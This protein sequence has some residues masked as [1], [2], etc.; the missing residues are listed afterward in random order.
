MP[1][2]SGPFDGS[3]WAESQ[4]MRHMP[5]AMPSGVI[6]TPQG[7][8][9][10]GPL[11]F[12]SSGLTITP[13]A[14]DAN[15]GGAG[16]SRTAALGSVT[17]A[18][19]ANSTL[20]RRDR[21]VLRR[22]IATHNVVLTV[23]QGTA[24]ATPVAPSITRDATTFDLPLF[25]FLVPPASGTNITGVVD[26]R[27][28]LDVNSL[29]HSANATGRIN[30]NTGSV[31]PDTWLTSVVTLPAAGLPT[32]V[33]VLALGRTGFGAAARE[34]GWEI[35]SLH[36]SATNVSTD[37][38][39]GSYVTTGSGEWGGIATS[40]Q[41]DIPAGVAPTFRLAFRAT[42]NAYNRGAVTWTRG[43]VLP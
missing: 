10:T 24:A 29:F 12:A 25:S 8:A 40:L 5:S 21:L 15:V 35:T 27:Q 39:T 7:A 22:S 36:A 32:T 2:A 19:N 9:T 23:I 41:M 37:Y 3:P 6:G 4:W 42:G 30:V 38:D 11:G 33:V 14:G 20:S 28:W 43:P 16:Y 34:I 26:E 1:D 31:A 13:L 17:T 18:A